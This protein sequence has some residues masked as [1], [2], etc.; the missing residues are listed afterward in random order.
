M[1]QYKKEILCVHAD[2]IGIGKL[3]AGSSYQ[4]NEVL[5][6]LLLETCRFYATSVVDTQRIYLHVTLFSTF[7]TDVRM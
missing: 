6:L 3:I 2:P 7:D 5:L 1:Q 4:R